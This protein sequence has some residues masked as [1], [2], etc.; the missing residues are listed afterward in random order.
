MHPSLSWCAACVGLALAGP[1]QDDPGPFVRALRLVQR[2]G[3]AAAVDP[4][5]DTRTKG[6]L[7]RAL[8]KAGVLTGPGVQGLMDPATF[9]KLA[10]DDGRLDADEIR[11]ALADVPASRAGL[12]PAVAAHTDWLATG[13][14]QIGDR[15]R[16]AAATLAEWVAT[17]YEPG[18]PLPALCICTGNSRRSIL[19]AVMGN[20]AADY[21]GLP[22]VRFSSGGTAPSAFNPRTIAALRAIGVEIEPTGEEAPRGEPATANPVHRVRWGRADAATALEFSKLYGDPSNPPR[23]F[24][25]LMVCG[26]ADESCPAVRG[27]SVRISTPYLDPKIYDDGAYESA[28]YA[29]RRDDMGRMLL[30]ALIQARRRL[31]AGGKPGGAT[32]LRP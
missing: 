30:S 26:E 5:N 12:H 25:A 24:A 19:G 16:E 22:E 14:D 10:G 11:R 31:D 6:Q 9:R 7:A 20:I 2:H 32:P 27:A 4:A 28:K 18:R 21:C 8:G 13:L 3:T 17:N 1:P 15:H 23:G 29:E